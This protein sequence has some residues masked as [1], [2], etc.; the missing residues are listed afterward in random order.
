MG[1]PGR[2]FLGGNFPRLGRE[3]PKTWE[4]PVVWEFP[5]L[6]EFPKIQENPMAWEVPKP[7]EIPKSWETPGNSRTGHSREGNFPFL[8][9]GRVWEHPVEHPWLDDT[10]VACD[11]L[12][13]LKQHGTIQ[14]YIAAFDNIIVSLAE[15]PEVER[16]HTFMCSLKLYICKFIKA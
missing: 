12:H 1:I 10:N 8:T 2:D 6:Q 9:G 13:E 7:W 5:E 16:V 11:K 4:I 15:L 14:D 3:F